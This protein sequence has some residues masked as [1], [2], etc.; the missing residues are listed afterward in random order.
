[1]ILKPEVFE[2]PLV[3]IKKIIIKKKKKLLF[4]VSRLYLVLILN[5]CVCVCT[6]I[7]TLK[8]AAILLG[9]KNLNSHR[10]ILFPFV[11]VVRRVTKGVKALA[12]L[13]H[14][15]LYLSKSERIKFIFIP[16]FEQIFFTVNF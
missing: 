11:L 15:L 2:C 8:R 13:H 5:M 14:V 12:H 1:M 10:Q 4:I 16:V 3:I 6:Y 9:N 7:I